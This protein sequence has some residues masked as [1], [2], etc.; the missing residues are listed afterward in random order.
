[1]YVRRAG[2]VPRPLLH[3][4]TRTH[5]SASQRR[6]VLIRAPVIVARAR[7]SPASP[8]LGPAP[9]RPGGS[10][11][12]DAAATAAA[13]GRGTAAAGRRNLHAR[14]PLARLRLRLERERGLGG[15]CG[16]CVGGVQV[17]WGVRTPARLA[18]GAR[19]AAAAPGAL[20]PRLHPHRPSACR[21][22]CALTS[23]SVWRWAASSKTTITG[24]RS[25]SVSAGNNGGAAR[26]GVATIAP[27]PLRPLRAR[28]RA[29]N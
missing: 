27:A 12:S 19:A 25:C 7:A 13:G 29:P 14:E 23:P 20:H 6:G 3:T 9:P 24:W 22:S 8:P 15:G 5:T 21:C 2:C 4:D 17:Q 18:W 16:L 28:A 10:A 26:G 11:R 1:M